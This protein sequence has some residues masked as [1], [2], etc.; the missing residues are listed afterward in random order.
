MKSIAFNPRIYDLPYVAAGS[1]SS[2][3]DLKV[4]PA[5]IDEIP[6][7]RSEP[8]L[9]PLVDALNDP[10]AVFM[11]HSCAVAHRRPGT[12]DGPKFASPSGPRMP[13]AGT[14]PT[15]FSHS[16]IWHILRRNGTKRYTTLTPPT[17]TCTT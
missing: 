7:L 17:E 11:T 8:R 4:Q 5:R 13:C 3:I 16:G 9:K 1:V 6:E 15:Y 2:Y 14:V 10:S 12:Q